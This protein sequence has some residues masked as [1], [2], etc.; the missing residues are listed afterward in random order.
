MLGHPAGI[1]P[2]EEG[3]G[4][5]GMGGHRLVTPGNVLESPPHRRDRTTIGGRDRLMGCA[6]GACRGYGLVVVA[7]SGASV[8]VAGDDRGRFDRVGG[9]P[10]GVVPEL[11]IVDLRGRS[12][13]SGP[14][15]MSRFESAH[16]LGVLGGQTQIAQRQLPI[17]SRE[18]E[19]HLEWG[20][21]PTGG[22]R[23]QGH[24]SSSDH[25]SHD[26]VSAGI[27]ST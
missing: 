10:I 11:E 20:T 22:Q 25:R 24:S 13:D 5:F 14:E 17:G 15:S 4:Q 12:P 27:R 2:F 19:V 23:L 7:N 21:A 16:P 1:G 6:G 18:I 9:P 3:L 8:P 26:R